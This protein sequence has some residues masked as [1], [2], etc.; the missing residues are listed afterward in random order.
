[1]GRT[2][3]VLQILLLVF[4]LGFGCLEEK[5]F[6][7]GKSEVATNT[8]SVDLD[9]DGIQDYAVY[10]FAPVPIDGAGMKVQRQMTVSVQTGSA[11]TSINPDLTDV[12]LLVADQSLAEFSKSRTQAD[13]ACSEANGLS[14]FACRD[15]ISCSS[16]CSTGSVR[17]KKMAAIYEE[18]LGGS[19]MSYVQKNSEIQA[20]ILDTRRMALT[21]RNASDEEKRIP[22]QDARD[23]RGG[24]GHKCQSDLHLSRPDAVQ[25]FRLRD[26]IPAGCGRKDRE[27]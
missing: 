11:Y 15:V 24:R 8:Q 4:L 2:T 26:A 13:T 12:D 18:P 21:L 1:M 22:E 25:P 16:M 23:C 5:S 20:R 14:S 9:N 7:S 17:C 3:L 10:D 6:P 27:L 19:M